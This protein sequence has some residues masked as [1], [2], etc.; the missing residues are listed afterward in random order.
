M[1]VPTTTSI[2]P[3]LH[4]NARFFAAYIVRIGVPGKV[5]LTLSCRL[6]GVDYHG[7]NMPVSQTRSLLPI[8]CQ[9]FLCGQVCK[10]EGVITFIGRF[11]HAG[12][13]CAQVCPTNLTL[14]FFR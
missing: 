10:A 11:L 4:A 6:N 13:L 3:S 7:T 12:F 9:L 8:L 2:L 14:T 1:D 5:R